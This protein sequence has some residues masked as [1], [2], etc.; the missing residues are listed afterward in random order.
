MT[1]LYIIFTMTSVSVETVQYRLSE[2]ASGLPGQSYLGIWINSIMCYV[3]TFRWRYEVL[4][5]TFILPHCFWNDVGVIHT[6]KFESIHIPPPYTGCA[7]C[8]QLMAQRFTTITSWQQ[9]EA[10]VIEE[11]SLDYHC[12]VIPWRVYLLFAIFKTQGRFDR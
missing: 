1:V 5:I 3:M 7:N 10:V 9:N 2:Y 12:L 11:S 6:K 4:E 8:W